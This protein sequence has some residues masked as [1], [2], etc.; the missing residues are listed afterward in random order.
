MKRGL[1]LG[2]GIAMVLI[3]LG[4]TIFGVAAMVLVGPDGTFSIADRH[5]Q[6][7]GHALVFDELALRG[8]LP[9]SGDL[10]TTLDLSV[11]GA[12]QDVFVGIG[13]TPL[14]R[15]Y[16]GDA[17]IDKVVQV[18]WPGG[19][20]TE[21]VPGTGTPRP[22]GGQPFWVAANSGRAASISWTVQ[23]G[24]WTVVVMNANASPGV[25]VTGSLSVSLPILGPA[26]VLTLVFGVVFLVAGVLL[27]I[28]GA[29]TPRAAEAGAAAFDGTTALA[30]SEPPP[31]P[32]PDRP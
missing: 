14:V 25:D 21:P 24:D 10:A 5:A 6:G 13:P 30:S 23:G 18:N 19:V 20:R 27:T 15:R 31:P 22:P 8:N 7:D 17:S 16:L 4:A 28:S 9:T 12:S 2:F 29:K 11:Q 26:G 1:K 32:R 3:G